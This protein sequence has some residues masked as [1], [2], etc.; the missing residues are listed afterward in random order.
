[1]PVA[2][3]L[4][5]GMLTL[6]QS[7]TDTTNPA[8]LTL[9]MTA[10]TNHK[11]YFNDPNDHLSSDFSMAVNG[12]ASAS[13]GLYLAPSPNDPTQ[14]VAIGNPNTLSI[15]INSLKDVLNPALNIS[16]AVTI[17]TPNIASFLNGASLDL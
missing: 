3:R 16:N 7:S 17:T 1:G 13:A 15:T 4:K 10:G 8:T 2:I 9:G 5:N 14:D 6:S 11:H 12:Y